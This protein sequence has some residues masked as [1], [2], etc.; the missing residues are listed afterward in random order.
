[1]PHPETFIIYLCSK[2]KRPFADL[3]TRK[4]YIFHTWLLLICFV[5]GQYMVYAHQHH[6]IKA[7]TVHVAKNSSHQAVTE[8]CSLCDVMH[9]SAM[10]AIV[11]ANAGSEAALKHVFKSFSYCFRSI[12]RILSPG[13][14]PP[15]AACSTQA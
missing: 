2:L 9:H 1:M 12:P 11:H 10:V 4:H 8:K 6:R 15:S 13:R 7:Y 5:A 14:A 3:K